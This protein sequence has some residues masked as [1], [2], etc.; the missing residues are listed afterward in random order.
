M[1]EGGLGAAEGGAGLGALAGLDAISRTGV[2]A[3]VS[4]SADDDAQVVAIDDTRCL[5]LATWDFEAVLLANPSLA[6]AILRGLAERLRNQT[7]QQHH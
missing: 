5:A 7:E 6:L 3:V 1:G 4:A 2:S